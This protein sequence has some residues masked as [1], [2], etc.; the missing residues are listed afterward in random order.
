MAIERNP[1]GGLMKTLSCES[2]QKIYSG[3][4]EIEKAVRE[5]VRISPTPTAAMLDLTLSAFLS[6][7]NAIL[8][9][10]GEEP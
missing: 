9:Q 4:Q 3:V 5:K 7:V 8:I 10:L 6:L 2:L 1:H